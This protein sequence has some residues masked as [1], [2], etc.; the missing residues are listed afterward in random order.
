MA[1]MLPGRAPIMLGPSKSARPEARQ[2]PPV[3]IRH[4]RP[5]YPDAARTAGVRGLVVVSF[6][7]GADG[8]VSGAAIERSV[9][10]L[11]QAALEAVR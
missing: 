11:D 4:V 5:V 10:L 3:L 7:V 6:S 8:T 2:R 1:G 9:P